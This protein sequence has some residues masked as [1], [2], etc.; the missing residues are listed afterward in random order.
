MALREIYLWMCH[1]LYNEFAWTYDTAASLVSLGRWDE[2]RREALAYLPEHGPVLEIGF[3]TGELLPALAAR[4]GRVYG[5]EPS[6][7]MQTITRRKLRRRGLE[8]R[9]SR[10]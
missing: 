6:P 5:L 3:G 10:V 4:P 2:W 1:R 8:G 7:A 9:V